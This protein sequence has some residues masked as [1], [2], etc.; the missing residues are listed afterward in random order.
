MKWNDIIDVVKE[1]INGMRPWEIMAFYMDTANKYMTLSWEDK[2]FGI[3]D[4]DAAIMAI[5]EAGSFR[6]NMWHGELNWMYNMPKTSDVHM[7]S[8]YKVRIYWD[9]FIP[10]TEVTYTKEIDIPYR[11]CGISGFISVIKA[12]MDEVMARKLANDLLE[13]SK[14]EEA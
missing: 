10:G 9:E 11:D 7:G 5:V 1:K 6:L 3:P 8:G 2:K 13:A 14:E 4:M 12:E